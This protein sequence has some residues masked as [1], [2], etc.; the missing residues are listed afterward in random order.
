MIDT[1]QAV[2]LFVIVLLTILFIVLGI[3]VF[4]ILKDLRLT[5]QRTNNIL[6]DVEKISDD[7]S[8]SINSISSFTNMI[9]GST[10]VSAIFKVL[11][12]FRGRNK[13]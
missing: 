6:E 5:I 9:G 4:Y 1:V 10:A 11:S 7:V 12:M 13:E 2:L 3:Q 8:N